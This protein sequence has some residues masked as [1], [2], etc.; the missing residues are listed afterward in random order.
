MLLADIDGSRSDRVAAAGRLINFVAQHIP[1]VP[2][3]HDGIFIASGGRD[4]VCQFIVGRF[5]QVLAGQLHG[6]QNIAIQSHV[7][8]E[9]VDIAVLQIRSNEIGGFVHFV[10]RRLDAPI[11]GSGH[12]PPVD[13]DQCVSDPMLPV[14]QTVFRRIPRF[15][16]DDQIEARKR[17]FADFIRIVF[18]AGFMVHPIRFVVK[19][20]FHARQIRVRAVLP[21]RS[22]D[23]IEA[24]EGHHHFAF[25]QPHSFD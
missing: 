5:Q 4:G 11:H 6:F 19:I 8:D 1:I 10:L 15:A 16:C 18:D 25:L 23:V 12:F 2:Y 20:L 7:K 22:D 17:I 21:V 24:A 3:Q 9:A 14:I 13:S